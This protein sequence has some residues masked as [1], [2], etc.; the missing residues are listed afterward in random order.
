M[1][2]Q[3]STNRLFLQ[4]V[5]PVP[6]PEPRQGMP[7]LP[8]PLT[9]FVGRER[10]VAAVVE[11]IRRPGVRMVTLTGPGGV[12]KT[13][14]AIRVT[15]KVALAFPDGVCFIALAAVSDPDLVPATIAVALDI[16]RTGDR[17]DET[18]I[19][20]FLRDRRMLLVLDNFE[21]LAGAGSLLPTLLTTCPGLSILVTSRTVL[22]LSGEHVVT[23]PPLSLPAN[24]AV[25][26]GPGPLESE[27]VRLF[28]E[29][30]Q[31]ARSDF[32]LASADIPIVAAICAHLDGLPL[33]IELAAAQ[34]RSLPPSALLAQMDHRLALLQ[35]GPNDQPLRLRTMR[36]AI[37]WSYALLSEQEQILLRRL[38]VFPGSFTLEAAQAVCRS[39][40][41]VVP[42]LDGIRSLVDQSLVQCETA[43]QGE[44]RFGMLVT[45]RVFG[46]E[47]LAE[48]G[49]EAAVRDAHADWFLEAAGR[50]AG[51]WCTPAEPLVVRWLAAEHDNLR[52]ALAWLQEA[53]RTVDCVRLVGHVWYFWHLRGH[54]SEARTWLD[55]AVDWSAGWRTHDRFR[56]LNGTAALRACQGD[57]AMGMGCDEE[58]LSIA[59][60]LGDAAGILHSYTGLGIAASMLGNADEAIRIH[61]EALVALDGFG[62]SLPC[63]EMFRVVQLNNLSFCALSKSDYA[64]A[65]RWAEDAR[66]A[67]RLSGSQMGLADSLWLLA[68]AAQ[69]QGDNHG[70][71]RYYRESMD[72]PLELREPQTIAESLDRIAV[73]LFEAGHL[74][75]AIRV[76]G[77]VVQYYEDTG[78]VPWSD[79]DL[80]DRERVLSGARE[81]FGET[82]VEMAL[83]EGR[84]LSPEQAFA[85]AR[86][87]FDATPSAYPE[88]RSVNDPVHKG[89]TRREREVLTL[90]VEGHSDREI[91]SALSIGRRT[92]ETHVSSLLNKMGLESRTAVAT[93][94]VRHGLA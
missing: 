56:V 78:I 51:Q 55:R 11:L 69:G 59:K 65:A 94:A 54:W 63:P 14:M 77:I 3:T 26:N 39:D 23:I 5:A 67:Q 40:G 28:V 75:T 58:A 89:L 88:S 24:D 10:E 45:I 32:T 76:V 90:L 31:A 57:V 70:A 61:S 7:C 27:A 33:G 47:E 91:A 46:L 19:E 80:A 21:H 38:A 30:A 16:P 71:A 49:E 4:A 12:G 22:H 13:R 36:A 85:E 44:L 25:T 48:H 18:R 86:R 52:A 29:R 60:E 66:A 68:L 2:D 35:G 42:I 20:G 50:A 84:V 34:V 43:D 9:S 53:G 81:R 1:D 64:Q 17:S 74:L 41:L 79:Q 15:D 62:D 82:A 72:I 73:L 92:V 87:M 8:V 93:Y 37:A 83:A 6:F